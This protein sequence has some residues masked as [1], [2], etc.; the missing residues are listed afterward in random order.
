MRVGRQPR[1]NPFSTRHVRPGAIPF[2][3]PPG[4][5]ATTLTARLERQGWWGQVIGPHGSGK[6]TLLAALVLELRRHRPVDVVELHQDDRRLPPTVWTMPPASAVLVVDGY[7][8]VSWWQRRRLQAHC[9]RSGLGLLVTAHRNLGLPDL[10]RTQVTLE[11]A[12][13]I[14]TGLVTDEQRTLVAD[15]DLER[16][17]ARHRGNLREVLFGLYDRCEQ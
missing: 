1:S 14:V 13:A 4:E 10:Y 8:Q 15:V 2:R 16:E 7:E 17:L 6:S 9:R 5:D 11:L 3:F 12:E